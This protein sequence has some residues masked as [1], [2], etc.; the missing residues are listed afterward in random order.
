MPSEIRVQFEEKYR[1]EP[2]WPE[3]QA[4]AREGN[5]VH[6]MDSIIHFSGLEEGM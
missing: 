3:L 5:V 6:V 2:V 4:K 1:R